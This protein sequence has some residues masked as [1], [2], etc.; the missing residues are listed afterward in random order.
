MGKLDSIKSHLERQPRLLDRRETPMR[1]NGLMYAIHGYGGFRTPE[2]MKCIKFLVDKGAS[3]NSKD[4]AGNTP[5]HHCIYRWCIGVEEDVPMVEVA[6][7]FL[8]MG[9]DINIMNRLGCSPAFWCTLYNQSVHRNCTGLGFVDLDLGSSPGWWAATVATY[10][11]SRM[12]EHPKSKSIQP[13][14]YGR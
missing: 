12:V 3:V 7:Y 13:R 9:A 2:H 6:N 4:V 8:H 14:S 1:L 5:L 10:C 11:P